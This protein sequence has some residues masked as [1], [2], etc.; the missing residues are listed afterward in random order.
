M[1]NNCSKVVMV[2]AYPLYGQPH[3]FMLNICNSEHLDSL[4]GSW[5]VLPWVDIGPSAP[6]SFPGV[7]GR[8]RQNMVK[9]SETAGSG[10]DYERNQIISWLMFLERPNDQLYPLCRSSDRYQQPHFTVGA[11]AKPLNVRNS[12]KILKWF[13]SQHKLCSRWHEKK[14]FGILSMVSCDLKA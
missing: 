5:P 11:N 2:K 6:R 12:P 7:P 14:L 8:P 4:A 9:H 3:S 10:S 1:N 13:Q